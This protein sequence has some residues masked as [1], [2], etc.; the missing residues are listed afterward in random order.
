MGAILGKDKQE[1]I[2]YNNLNSKIGGKYVTQKLSV[3]RD[4][5]F[6]EKWKE[7]PDFLLEKDDVAFGIE[8]F[9]VDQVYLKNRAAGRVANERI[10]DVYKT[11]HA[12]LLDEQFDA[13][14]ASQDIG[15]EMQFVFGL[16]TQFDYEISMNQFERVFDKHVQKIESYRNNLS[17]YQKMHLFFLIESSSMIFDRYDKFIRC[18]AVRND[19]ALVTIAGKGIVITKRMLEIF[20]KQIGVLD[21]IILQNYSFIDLEKELKAMVYFD[22]SSESNFNESIRAQ[23]IQIYEKYYILAP[24][25]NLKI[26]LE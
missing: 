6:V 25:V 4:A 11:H 26:N 5:F 17:N 7:S 13:E 9:T 1:I 12:T 15:N 23:K 16:T 19:G 20:K 10:M 2:C 14:A 3:L 24:K 22:L 8:H 18:I 21:G